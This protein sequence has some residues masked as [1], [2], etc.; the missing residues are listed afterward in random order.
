MNNVQAEIIPSDDVPLLAERVTQRRKR[1]DW[2]LSPG[3]KHPQAFFGEGGLGLMHL[4]APTNLELRRMLL[5]LRRKLGWS[6]SAAA[7]VMGVTKSAIV[8]WESG[9]RKP[10]GASAKMIFFLH[11]Q[12]VNK[13]NKVRNAWDLAFWGKAPCRGSFEQLATILDIEPTAVVSIGDIAR[14]LSVLRRT[15]S[16]PHP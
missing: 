12:L 9:K 3:E 16:H 1:S 4:Y 6:Q 2:V 5:A 14:S 15:G 13:S 11:S 8:K 7:G 10:T